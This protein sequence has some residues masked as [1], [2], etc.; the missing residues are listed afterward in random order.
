VVKPAARAKTLR[1]LFVSVPGTSTSPLVK[2]VTI[3]ASVAIVASAIL[4][5][6]VFAVLWK[7]LPRKRP[8]NSELGRPR[9]PILRP[10]DTN[11]P[12][13]MKPAYLDSPRPRRASI[14]GRDPLS[15][16][17]ASRQ[18]GFIPRAIPINVPMSATGSNV[19]SMQFQSHRS[20]A[21]GVSPEDLAEILNELSRHYV[22][23]DPGSPGPRP[24]H[25][26]STSLTGRP[27]GKHIQPAV[28]HSIR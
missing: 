17:A 28:P 24:I 8:Y 5:V 21:P 20:S 19:A 11:F 13:E 9:R 6:I 15:P 4:I 23:T 1:A 22:L 18:P 25:Q 14:I 27:R 26:Y 10:L 2:S 3:G 7:R 12:A 16:L